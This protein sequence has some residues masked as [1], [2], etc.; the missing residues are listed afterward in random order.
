[1][2]KILTYLATLKDQ[3]RNETM[4]VS[5]R[6]TAQSIN[7]ILKNVLLAG[8]TRGG[9]IYRSRERTRRHVVM[10]DTD[11]VFAAPSLNPGCIFNLF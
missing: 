9:Q 11:K 10:G 1:M 5:R 2:L 4:L 7:I 3:W 6:L 8:E